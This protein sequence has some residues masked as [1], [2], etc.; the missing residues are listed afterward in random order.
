MPSSARSILH[1]PRGLQGFRHPVPC[2]LHP[3]GI[4]N[5]DALLSGGVPRGSIIELCGSASS[6]RTSLTLS[7]L[8]KATE[9]QETCAYVDVSDALDPMSVASAGVDLKRLLW[10][11]CGG[12]TGT[13]STQQP[14]QSS[15]PAPPRARDHDPSFL[16][17]PPKPKSQVGQHP[18]DQI[19]G[20]ESSIPSL[21]RNTERPQKQPQAPQVPAAAL[22]FPES[23]NAPHILHHAS[24]LQKFDE[25]STSSRARQ[26]LPQKT[27]ASSKPWKRLEQA[28]KA[29]DLLLH[30]GGWGFVVFDLGNI[31]WV[32]ARRIEMS[33]WFRFRRVIEHT[34]TILLLLGEES[35]AKSCASLVLQCQRKSQNWNCTN[36][37]NQTG[38]VVLG[39]FEIESKI[40]C[41]RTGLPPMDSARW[42]ATTAATGRDSRAVGAVTEKWTEESIAQRRG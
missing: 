31:S 34:P 29:T 24:A 28:L 5:L 6:G 10:I 22:P 16:E 38:V 20:V 21:M 26:R 39:G 30:S 18:R 40:L 41:S 25:C 8:A 2:E 12:T 15:I 36:S 35:C 37:Q 1:L 4:P 32:D 19:R 42:N 9:R 14:C 13:T 33:T 3:T 7:L 23:A 27:R 17:N 11:R